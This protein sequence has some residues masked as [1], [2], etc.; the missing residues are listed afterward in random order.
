MF[1]LYIYITYLN[2][3]HVNVIHVNETVSNILKIIKSF[4]NLNEIEMIL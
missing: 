1:H 4:I 2:V 3:I